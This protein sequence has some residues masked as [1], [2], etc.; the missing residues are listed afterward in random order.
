MK[1]PEQNT[2]AKTLLFI[3]A[4][5]DDDSL[6]AGTMAKLVRLGWKVHEFVCTAGQNG[7]PNLGENVM[8][9]MVVGR[10]SETET[11]AKLIQSEPPYFYKSLG[12]FLQLDEDIVVELVRY[13]RSVRPAVTILLNRMDYHFEHRLSHDIALRALEIA[14]RS[15]VL[16]LGPKLQ[17]GII[18]QTDGLN[19]L[20]NPLVYLDVTDDWS[21][22]QQACMSAYRERLG[23]LL[24][25]LDGM[26]TMRGGRIGVARAECFELLNPEW[27]KMNAVSASILADFVS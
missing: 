26:S 13:M 17:H 9:D 3:S 15:S 8:S 2:F 1:Q 27:Y 4:H 16:E 7:K 18:M 20:A 12:K 11:F 21:T 14:F 23:D 5:P 25:L 22:G 24:K 6:V 19:A 10:H